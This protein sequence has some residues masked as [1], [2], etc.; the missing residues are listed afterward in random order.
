[1]RSLMSGEKSGY[2]RC[3]LK[4]TLGEIG[5]LI[6]TAPNAIWCPVARRTLITLTTLDGHVKY[7][8]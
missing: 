7:N 6:I 2:S 4:C 3:Y 5:F 8:A 1:M